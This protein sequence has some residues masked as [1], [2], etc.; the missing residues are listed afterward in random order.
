MEYMSENEDSPQ[1]SGDEHSPY[2]FDDK[3]IWH[4]VIRIWLEAQDET[5]TV[6]TWR[7]QVRHVPSGRR[8]YVNGLEEIQAAIKR[9]MHLDGKSK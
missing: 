9:F 6:F 1:V 2:S 3:G 5:A 4:F 7:G 8:I